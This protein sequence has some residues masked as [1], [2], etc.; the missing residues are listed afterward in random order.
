MFGGFCFR[1]DFRRPCH[2]GLRGGAVRM[3]LDQ[4]THWRKVHFEGLKVGGILVLDS[5]GIELL[6]SILV[7]LCAQ[8]FVWILWPLGGHTRASH[9]WLFPPKMKA[10][11]CW[12]LIIGA[13]LC[14]TWKSHKL[15]LKR[16]N[17]CNNPMWL[18]PKPRSVSGNL[19]VRLFSQN[20]FSTSA[21]QRLL[22][23]TKSGSLGFQYSKGRLVCVWLSGT[24]SSQP[25]LCSRL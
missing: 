4:E 13:L 17:L 2:P 1:Q 24:R 16:V 14:C 22:L 15:C 20:Q 12:N 5:S 7:L 25:D 19:F 8:I 18:R 11:E 10:E 6:S 9:T 3:S 21:V 23:P